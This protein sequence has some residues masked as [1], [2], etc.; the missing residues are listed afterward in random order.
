LSCLEVGAASVA[1]VI[2]QVQRESDIPSNAGVER[3]RHFK[4]AGSGRALDH[5]EAAETRRI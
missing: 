2:G 1:V 3:A 5:R 4:D